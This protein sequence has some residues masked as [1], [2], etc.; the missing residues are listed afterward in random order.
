MHRIAAQSS[1]RLQVPIVH[2]RIYREARV[3][4]RRAKAK[5]KTK[6]KASSWTPEPP[7]EIPARTLEFPI[8]R[9]TDFLKFI[10][11]NNFWT[12]L[13]GQ[14]DFTAGCSMMTSFWHKY[15]I[16]FPGY[17]L[18]A[19]ADR[20]E[21]DLSHCLPCLVH[22]D[23]GTYY[24]RG[25]IMILQWQSVFGSGTT[26]CSKEAFADCLLGEAISHP[27]V[28]H[29][30][31]TLSSRLLLGVLPKEPCL[32]YINVLLKGY[33][34]KSICSNMRMSMRT[35]LKSLTSSLNTLLMIFKVRS[36]MG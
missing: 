34:S 8:I 21:V 26:K 27:F 17:E 6:S 11:A 7:R 18:F 35:P 32:Y 4:K 13:F 2:V 12:V 28:N 33:S 36:W 22:G 14:E 10:A 25:A 20:G 31:V 19:R 3:V 15:R 30:G 29:R 24:K 5:A 16:L 9:A 1:L 23:E